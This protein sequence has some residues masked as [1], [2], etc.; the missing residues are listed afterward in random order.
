MLKSDVYSL[1]QVIER[2]GDADC[3]LH[4]GLAG[5][6]LDSCISFFPKGLRVVLVRQARNVPLLQKTELIKV[7]YST[8]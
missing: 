7:S 2:V 6:F 4:S 5:Q 3:H 1:V 8:E